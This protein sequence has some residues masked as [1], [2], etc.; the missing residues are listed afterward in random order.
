MDATELSTRERVVDQVER[1]GSELQRRKSDVEREIREHPI[2]SIAI[3]L[4]CG[5]LLARLLD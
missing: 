2:R 4:G 1:V 5:Y 3:A